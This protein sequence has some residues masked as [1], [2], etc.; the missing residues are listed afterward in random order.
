MLLALAAV[1]LS[2]PLAVQDL[3]R[4][5]AALGD[6]VE[7][8]VDDVPAAGPFQHLD[9]LVALLALPLAQ[10]LVEEFVVDLG[11]LPELASCAHGHVDDATGPDVDETRVKLGRCVLLG[12]NVR[13]GTL[14]VVA[15]LDVVL[16]GGLEALGA[17]EV[18]D[19][20]A[21][22]LRQQDVLRL[23]VSVRDAHVMHIVD[24][25]HHL[26]EEAIGLGVLQLACGGDKRVKVTSGAIL[27]HLVVVALRVLEEVVSIDDAVVLERGG[28][29]ELVSQ[30][31]AV[32]RVGLV[33]LPRE[34][35]HRVQHL[36][37]VDLLVR[38]SHDPKRAPA[39]D[40]LALPVLL[41]ERLMLMVVIVFMVVTMCL[42][43]GRYAEARLRIRGRT[44]GVH[45]LL[46]EIHGK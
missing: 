2:D 11:L 37:V 29:A 18:S 38:D 45:L 26:L 17:A 40:L 23:E 34:L 25:S 41:E 3:Q 14:D 19:L 6:R 7:D 30:T 28:D 33:Q 32:L 42:P 5:D 22:V 20:H 8:G 24:G 15:E 9:G 39:N 21:A 46:P 43:D 31:L 13:R 10:V 36:L 27:H 1:D 35:L 4:S 44:M 12:R 16:P